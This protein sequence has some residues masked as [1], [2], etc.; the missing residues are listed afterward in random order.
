[1]PRRPRE[2]HPGSIQHAFN[3]GLARRTIF[4]TIEDIRYFLSLVAREV[5]K[6]LIEVLAYC[7]LTTHFHLVLRSCTGEMSRALRTIQNRYV[8][9]FNRRRKR[10]GALFR[11]RFGSRRVGSDAYWRTLLRYVD[12]NA[13][14]AGLVDDPR[15]YPH[16]SAWHYARSSGPIWLARYDVEDMVRTDCLVQA[17]EPGLYAKSVGLSVTPAEKWVV[18]QRMKGRALDEDPLDD[19]LGA[20]PPRVRSWMQRKAELADGTEPGIP[21]VSPP[22]IESFLSVEE[23]CAPDWKV[24]P[25]RKSRGG[26]E[27]LRV[28]LLRDLAGLSLA[29]IA[30][31]GR[32]SVSSTV[33]IVEAHRSLVLRDE[34]YADRAA[35]V[36]SAALREDFPIR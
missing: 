33:R 7:L 1:M 8:R 30:R 21:I 17:Y 36:L 5:R 26:W 13:V 18:E 35:R 31:R 32:L 22:T 19:L 24:R 15:L 28:G 34:V 4:E 2:D 25:T 6:G 9:W 27:V 29:E 20:A 11:G 3:R 23:A 16:C 10:D 12:S 14:D